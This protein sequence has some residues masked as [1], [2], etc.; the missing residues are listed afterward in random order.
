MFANR[1]VRSSEL[2]VGR[3]QRSQTTGERGTHD[4]RCPRPGLSIRL[5]QN[6]L[7]GRSPPGQ[8]GWPACSTIQDKRTNINTN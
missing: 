1:D 8:C 7:A 3:V 5:V 4:G 6:W 2:T